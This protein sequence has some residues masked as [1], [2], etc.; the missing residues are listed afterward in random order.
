MTFPHDVIHFLS[1]LV[2]PAEYIRNMMLPPVYFIVLTGFESF[3]LFYVSFQLI[4]SS[5]LRDLLGNVDPG[6]TVDNETF[7][8][9]LCFCSGLCMYIRT[10]T[11]LKQI[12]TSFLTLL[13]TSKW[14]FYLCLII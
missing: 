14:L 8:P 13:R 10:K 3:P 12:P 6:L 9:A 4:A 7:Q 1:G 11:S 5:L 2:P